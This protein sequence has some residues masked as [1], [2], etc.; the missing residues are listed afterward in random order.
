MEQ[1]LSCQVRI[2]LLQTE[3]NQAGWSDAKVPGAAV[4]FL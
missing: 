1:R 4:V 2:I 3:E